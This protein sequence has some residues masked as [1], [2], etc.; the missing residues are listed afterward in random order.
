MDYN[1][2]HKLQQEI[3]DQPMA[4]LKGYPHILGIVLARSYAR[5]TARKPGPPIL[6]GRWMACAD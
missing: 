6:P 3:L 2:H 4:I 5:R 1:Q